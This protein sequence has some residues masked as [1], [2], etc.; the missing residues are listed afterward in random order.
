MKKY[1]LIVIFFLSGCGGFFTVP[2]KHALE[3]P[4]PPIKEH[5]QTTLYDGVADFS[6][7]TLSEG[8]IALLGILSPGDPAGLTQNAVFELFQGLRTTFPKIRIIPRKDVAQKIKDA[9]KARD[10]E[11][12]L[13]SYQASR[14]MNV[15]RLREWGEIGG[16]RF[17]FIAQVMS[18]DKHTRTKTMMLGEKGVAGK[19][20]VFSSGP[21]HIPYDVQKNISLSG[22]L[23]DSRCGKAVWMGTT[24][25]KVREAGEIE[26]VRM[27]DLFISVSRNLIKTLNRAITA[28]NHN[29]SSHC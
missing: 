14:V 11:T 27:E 13:K 22:E 12:F 24:H 8:G 5:S 7:E 10:F 4:R 20:S 25:A 6:Y 15:S 18:I 29:N 28:N 19:V 1:A 23:W 17:L 3:Q 2:S 9:G 26:R 21:V 16:V